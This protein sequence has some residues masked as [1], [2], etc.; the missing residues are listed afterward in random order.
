LH[1]SIHPSIH[2]AVRPSHDT[3][4]A[5]RGTML[6][7]RVA[8][9][10]SSYAETRACARACESST[11]LMKPCRCE[12]ERS[13]A[14]CKLRVL[15]T[16]TGVPCNTRTITRTQSPGIRRWRSACRT[17]SHCVAATWLVAELH[18]ALQHRRLHRCV[19]LQ[20]CLSRAL[21][22]CRVYRSGSSAVAA[23]ALG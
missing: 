9:R 10:C 8:P 22:H 5:I 3:H 7:Q 15:W 20:R 13:Y 11:M 4:V 1:I 23:R 19:A 18:I 17:C 14:A 16:T 2:P 12:A 6:Q 21:L